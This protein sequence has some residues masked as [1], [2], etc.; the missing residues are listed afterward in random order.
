MK[1]GK[2]LTRIERIG[3]KGQIYVA[4]QIMDKVVDGFFPA[5]YEI[6]NRL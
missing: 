5:I 4:H 6:E 2:E 1:L 3:V